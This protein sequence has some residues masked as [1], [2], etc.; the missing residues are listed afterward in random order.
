[1]RKLSGPMIRVLK[2]LVQGLPA[3][4]HC[5]GM[6]EF[7]GHAR[8]MCALVSRGLIDRDDQI[9]TAGRERLANSQPPTPPIQ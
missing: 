1:M 3:G 4:N 6:S 9:T 5:R 2:N 7:G 8:V